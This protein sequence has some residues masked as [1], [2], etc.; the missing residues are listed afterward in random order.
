MW[1]KFL[2]PSGFFA[3]SGSSYRDISNFCAAID[4]L[5]YSFLFNMAVKHLL[6]QLFTFVSV[7]LFG[8]ATFTKHRTPIV[9]FYELKS[10]AQ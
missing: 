6:R 7:C 9:L 1:A 4:S 10:C 8:I 5:L 2:W 3:F